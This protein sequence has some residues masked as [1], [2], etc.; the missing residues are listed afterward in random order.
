MENIIR[1]FITIICICLSVFML[2]GC[3][4]NNDDNNDDDLINETPDEPKLTVE[5]DE[6]LY[7]SQ[8]GKIKVTS[9]YEN[10]EITINS[11]NKQVIKIKEDA[12]DDYIAE[13]CGVGS[14]IITITNLYG[15]AIS[16]VI[17]VEA[18]EGF[19]PPIN[20]IVVSLVEEGPYYPGVKYHVKTEVYPEIFNDTYQI[21]LSKYYYVD[22]E[23]NAIT[24]KQTGE[25]TVTVI[26]KI[27]KIK[28]E[29]TV[30][31]ELD[32]NREMYEILFV[33]NSL[34]NVNNIPDLVT[35]MI[36]A[37][38]VYVNAVVDAPG[39]VALYQH[40][41]TFYSLMDSNQFTHVILQETS[42][43]T[44][45]N[46]SSFERN[47]LKYNERI[48]EE[49]A[50]L[51]LY[52]TWGYNVDDFNGYSKYEMTDAVVAAYNQMAYE[53]G[54]KVSR[55]GEAF[56]YYELNYD[57]LPSLYLD[58]NHQSVYGAY[59]SACVHYCMITGRKA[60]ENTFMNTKIDQNVAEIIKEVADI[61]CFG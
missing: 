45:D 44:I 27:N 60:S 18:K 20:K 47:V 9:E 41:E 5:Y 35:N 39:G 7:Y 46:Y 31:V 34:T 30:D 33:G 23:E 49:E 36:K 56:R 43:G 48:L 54:A 38:G 59:L 12:E 1:K 55:V 17:T 42:F 3:N 14:S 15:E 52:Q 29:I 6:L 4:E 22:Y 28:G 32:P 19:A 61:I 58:M 11:L 8:V 10:D 13:A 40:E 2:F 53:T 50:E 51:I 57:D 21:D 25:M 16:I 24:F 26:S 37:D